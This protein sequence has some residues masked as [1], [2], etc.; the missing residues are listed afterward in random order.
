VSEATAPVNLVAGGARELLAV[1]A[2][3]PR[4]LVATLRG[5]PLLETVLLTLRL[6][7]TSAPVVFAVV[8]FGGAMLTVQAAASLAPMGGADVAGVVVGFG[9]I[10][11]VFPLLAAAAIAARSGAEF[12]SEIATMK[13]TQQIDA[14]EVMGV[15]P[16]RALAGPRVVAAVLGAPLCVLVA[17]GAGMLGA[18]AVGAFQLGIDR[19]AMWARLW[20]GIVIEDLHVAVAK[21]CV[22]G[23][24]LA[25]IAVREGLVATGGAA[26]VGRATNQAVIRAMIAVCLASLLLT[27]LVYGRYA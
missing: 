8:F 9:G 23:F 2:F 24:L 4:A 7:T 11:E 13:T 10:R 3:F 14:L 15:D 18:Q 17:C 6:V 25:A 16:L 20:S 19:G 12:A 5:P 22:L 21:G 27:S 1:A 26:G